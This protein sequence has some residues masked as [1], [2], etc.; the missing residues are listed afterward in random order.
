MTTQTR[1]SAKPAA[2][3][4]PAKTA[5]KAAVTEDKKAA[6]PAPAE[7]ELKETIVV[8]LEPV[9]AVEK[10]TEAVEQAAEEAVKA[11]V[12]TGEQLVAASREQVGKASA[13]FEQG[14]GDFAAIQKQALDAFIQ[15]G[16]ILAKGAEDLG[17]A[18]LSLVQEAAATNTE[19]VQAMF[20]AR[21]LQEVV[22]LQ[23]EYARKAIDRSVVEGGKLSEMTLKIASD[24][25]G[26][27]QAQF[28]SAVEKA[29]KP[30][31]A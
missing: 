30:L 27:I 4:A 7:P 14:Y 20:T 5:A 3:A 23:S 28:S 11:A 24:A 6:A 12:S 19:A 31:A 8:D 16:T 18:Y 1:H 10:A 22:D 29:L 25:V 26:P 17:K 13:A 2:K 21:T 9:E 15:T